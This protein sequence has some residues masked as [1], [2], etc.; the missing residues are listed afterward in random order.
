MATRLPS[1]LI[2]IVGTYQPNLKVLQPASNQKLNFGKECLL[3]FGL[4]KFSIHLDMA[5]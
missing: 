1:A 5:P 4:K 2:E 3:V